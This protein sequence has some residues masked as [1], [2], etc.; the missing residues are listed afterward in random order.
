MIKLIIPFVVVSV[1][2]VIGVS[3]T[4]A[5]ENDEEM[6]GI[7]IFFCVFLAVTVIALLLAKFHK[8][9]NYEFTENEIICYKR[10]TQL[11]TINISEIEKIQ[12]YYYKWRYLITIF[13]G[14]LPEGGCWSLHILMKDGTKKIL[15]FFQRK[16][17]EMLKEKIFGDL[18]TIS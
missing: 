17:V 16:D 18:L 11:C 7:L 2:C 1:L 3:I 10:K 13:F 4:L 8:S 12:F 14:E 5:F 15:R 9:K 6:D